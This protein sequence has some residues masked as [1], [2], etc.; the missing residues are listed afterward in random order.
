MEEFIKKY[1]KRSKYTVRN[2]RGCLT[3]F[4]DAIK[5]NPDTYFDK[6]TDDEIKKDVIK[7]LETITDKAPRTVDS[8]VYCL[9][10]FFIRNKRKIEPIFWKDLLEDREEKG[11]ISE[12]HIPTTDELKKM[13]THAAVRER[14]WILLAAT[15]GMRIGEIAQLIEDNLHLDEEP[16]RIFIPA[17]ITKAKTK[18]F[19]FITNEAADAIKEWLEVKRDYLCK[20][21]GKN[22]FKSVPGS[23]R[24]HDVDTDLVFPFKYDAFKKA[25][26]KLLKKTKLNQIDKR[27]KRHKLHIHCLRKFAKTR[28]LLTMPEAMTNFIIGHSGYLSKEYEKYEY[29]QI[30]PEYKKAMLNLSIFES[31]GLGEVYSE[32]EEVRRENAR[33]RQEMFDLRSYF[34]EMLREDDKKKQTR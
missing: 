21:N 25:W 1:E 29:V 13:L 8:R 31:P 11:S 24:F 20:I 4:Y 7:Y 2:Y 27:T 9:K 18:R 28:M 14:A 22:N 10:S 5:K 26:H 15:S 3:Q 34:R 6:I 30:A 32:L 33:L 16:P 17:K 23:R 19:T 12:D